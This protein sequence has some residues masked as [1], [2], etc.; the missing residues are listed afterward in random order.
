[1][2][3]GNPFEECYW[4]RNC[5]RYQGKYHCQFGVPN[6]I[7]LDNGTPFKNKY[8]KSF[9]ETYQVK[10]HKSTPYYPK[11]N[12]QAEATNKT[13]IRILSKIMD[14]F[15]GTWSEQLIV[16]QWAYRTSKRKPTRATPY[17]FVYGSQAM[18]LIE[19]ETLS[20]RMALALGIVL[21]PRTTRLETLEEKHDRAAKVM[22]RYHESITRA[23]NETVVPRKFEEG[24]LVW[25]IVDPIMRGQPLP[26]FFSK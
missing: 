17:S 11:G 18:L 20:A 15:G 2:G 7:L 23:Y 6:I 9:L 21:E 3:Q 24:D 5:E 8:V 25:K 10:Y 4:V 16:A 13:L 14:E 1:M 12:G 22:E 26:K 19:L